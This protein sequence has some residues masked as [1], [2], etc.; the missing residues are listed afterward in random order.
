MGRELYPDLDLWVTAKPFI[1][2]WMDEQS[3]IRSLFSGAKE[4]L[5]KFIEQLPHMPVMINE[6][7]R[8]IHDR[9][10]NTETESI[11]LQAIREEIKKAN[12]RTT[13]TISG[14]V[15]VVSAV[16]SSSPLLLVSSNASPI[17]WGLG[18]FGIA[19]LVGGIIKK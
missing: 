8:Q 12:Q 14:G 7:I 11:Q 15:L 5:P 10:N 3:G 9:N 13:I 1:Q 17:T 2:R 16:L 19:L 6:V 18:L 4:N